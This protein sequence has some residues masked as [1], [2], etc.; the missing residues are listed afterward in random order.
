[1]AVTEG[2]S[3]ADSIHAPKPSVASSSTV[4]SSPKI[5]PEIYK[6]LMKQL[7]AAT[8]ELSSLRSNFASLSQKVA[9]HD[10]RI[11]A[12]E[13]KVA[14]VADPQPQQFSPRL[15]DPYVPTS[16]DHPAPE[17]YEPIINH[18]QSPIVYPIHAPPSPPKFSNVSP[19]RQSASPLQQELDVQG[20]RVDKL[21]SSLD[22]IYATLSA[23][24]GGSQEG[25]Q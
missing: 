17:P 16:W 8:S 4:S 1:V 25:P 19:P 11:D 12:L 23:I 5:P 3:L 10:Q 22:N 24:N 2:S 13:A 18:R 7:Q 15:T 6:D 14:F 9:S 20:M 21:Q